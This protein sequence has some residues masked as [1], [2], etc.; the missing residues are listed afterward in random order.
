MRAPITNSR[1]PATRHTLRRLGGLF[2]HQGPRLGHP[3]KLCAAPR[4][5]ANGRTRREHQRASAL[6]VRCIRLPAGALLPFGDRR[7]MG[8]PFPTTF[9]QAQR[10]AARVDLE[11]LQRGGPP[12]LAAAR[13]WRRV[14][15]HL[16]LATTAA[17]NLPLPRAA[18]P[19]CVAAR[20][21]A[22]PVS[23]VRLQEARRS[24]SRE[25][26]RER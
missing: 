4:A 20:P 19:F 25:R 24:R 23:R 7:R 26:S 18:H 9:P 11:R 13:S 5:E 12:R 1:R 16:S 2:A 10:H 15:H 8:V 17:G 21:T 6:N 14:Y 22:G 3:S